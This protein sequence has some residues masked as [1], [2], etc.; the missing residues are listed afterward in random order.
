MFVMTRHYDFAQRGKQSFRWAGQDLDQ[1]RSADGNVAALRFEGEETLKRTSGEELR[2]RHFTFVESI[3]LPQGGVFRMNFDLWTDYEHA[4]LAFRARSERPPRRRDRRTSQSRGPARAA[5]AALADDA[6][7]PRLRR[8][9]AGRAGALTSPRRL[10]S[11]RAVAR[12]AECS[13]DAPSGVS[14][15]EACEDV[16]R[17]ATRIDLRGPRDGAACHL[18]TA[19][20]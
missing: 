7:L 15:A 6:T 16:A 13:H 17:V 5:R 14:A 4:P 11:V 10:R 2:I 1:S 20:E 19:A 9:I 12:S 3:P 18:G 8:A